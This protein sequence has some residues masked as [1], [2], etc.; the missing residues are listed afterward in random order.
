[1]ITDNAKVS[2]VSNRTLNAVTDRSLD[3]WG[4]S[5]TFIS[6]FSTIAGLT[7][8]SFVAEVSPYALI[9]RYEVVKLSCGTSLTAI[10]L[11]SSLAWGTAVKKMYVIGF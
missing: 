1:M 11:I 2:L 6:N 5:E 7:K 10:S 4:A 3:T 9:A 8:R